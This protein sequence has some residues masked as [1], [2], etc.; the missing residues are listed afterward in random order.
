MKVAARLWGCADGWCGGVAWTYLSEFASQFSCVVKRFMALGPVRLG[1]L[2]A[3][4]PG[5]GAEMARL[6]GKGICTGAF[7]F[8]TCEHLFQSLGTEIIKKCFFL[9]YCIIP[10]VKKLYKFILSS[11]LRF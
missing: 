4:E 1:G 11:T 8:D 5:L 7:S 6:S 9:L 3:W 2:D 10:S